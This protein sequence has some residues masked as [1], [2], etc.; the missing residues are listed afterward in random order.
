MNETAAKLPQYPIVMNMKSV[1]PSL[2][3]QLIAEI[4]D[5]SCF[6]H[7][8]AITAFAGVDPY[9]NESKTYEQ[10]SI[11]TF[12]RGYLILRKTLFQVMDVLIKTMPQNDP[13]YQFLDKKRAQGK[14]YYVYMTAEVNNYL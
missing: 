13:V 12:R 1:G 11:P 9:V 2:G 7:K 10:E 6:S 5:V 14:P 8:S 3:L 4:G